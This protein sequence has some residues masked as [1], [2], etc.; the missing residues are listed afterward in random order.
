MAKDKV[1]VISGHI[2]AIVREHQAKAKQK[3]VQVTLRNIGTCK[4]TNMKLQLNISYNGKVY[5]QLVSDCLSPD[6]IGRIHETVE[7]FCKQNAR[8]LKQM[9]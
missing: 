4:G 2:V 7:D 9:M 1:S 3:F 5:S 6:E 8:G